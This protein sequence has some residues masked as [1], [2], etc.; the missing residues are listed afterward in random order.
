MTMM[1]TAEGLASRL[2]DAKSI[3]TSKL[4][5]T[6][7]QAVAGRALRDFSHGGVSVDTGVTVWP[8]SRKYSTRRSGTSGSSSTTR[9]LKGREAGWGMAIARHLERG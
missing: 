1:T 6:D 3:H 9:T 2:Q 8:L 4:Q 7:D 5:V